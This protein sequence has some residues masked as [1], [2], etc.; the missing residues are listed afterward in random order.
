[1]ARENQGLQIALIVFVML[2]IILGVTTFIF[3]GR[4]D[5]ALIKAKTETEKAVADRTQATSLK[6]DNAKLKEMIGVEAGKTIAEVEAIFNDDVKKYAGKQDD[7][8]ALP[9]AQ[10]FYRPL[11]EQ[12]YQTLNARDKQIV[13]KEEQIRKC[14]EDR[15]AN[16]A[17]L[18]DQVKK[19]QE[20]AVAASDE[21]K[22]ERETFT[23]ERTRTTS[24]KTEIAAQL[25]KTRKESQEEITKKDESIKARE[26]ETDRLLEVNTRLAGKL[27]TVTKEVADSPLGEIRWVNQGSHKVWINLGRADSLPSQISFSVYSPNATDMTKAGRKASIEVTQITG[28]KLAEARIVEDKDSDPIMP[29]DK[30]Y[31]PIWRPGEK[32]H[33]ALAGL[34][35]LNGDG[36][37]DLQAVKNLITMNGGV[38]DCAPTASGDE[39]EGEMTVNTRYLVLGSEPRGEGAMTVWSRMDADAKRLGIKKITLDDLIQQMGGYRAE[40][41]ATQFGAGGVNKAA[42]GGFTPRKPPGAG[43]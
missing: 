22:K 24:D 19:F 2:T 9:D 17:K 16:E 41:S 1:M 25:D 43:Q 26:K 10:K 36:R 13:A 39:R 29:G 30:I 7:G 32:K 33:F 28:E 37:S 38:V 40:A 4:Y 34:M 21:L 14:E 31:T 42:S 18:Q 3:Y 5:E 11:L 35:D 27:E 20:A 12:L 15:A 8:G 23:A 6:A